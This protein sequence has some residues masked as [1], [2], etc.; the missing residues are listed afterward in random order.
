MSICPFPPTSR[1][2]GAR[3]S[4]NRPLLPIEADL[5]QL[6]PNRGETPE[7]HAP[8]RRSD[9]EDVAVWTPA[10]VHYESTD[11]AI[12]VTVQHAAGTD[13]F[14]LD[15]DFPFLL[16]TWEEA[17]GSRLQL[18]R[19]L[20]IDYWNYHGLGDRRRA[21]HQTEQPS[22]E[23]DR[24]VLPQAFQFFIHRGDFNQTRHVSPRSHRNSHMRHMKSKDFIKFAVQPYP[25]D[26]VDLVPVLECDHEV[27]TLLNSSATDAEDLGHIDNANAAHFHVIASQF[28]S[29]C[30]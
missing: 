14:M 23:V 8:V 16:R 15:R 22:I 18:K 5:R 24:A 3:G 6:G 20:K 4:P 12:Y 28:G 9:G 13:R 19:S 27:E 10:Q 11:R 2:P 1:R 21:L 17:D 25:I 29:C 7:D 30:H 26:L